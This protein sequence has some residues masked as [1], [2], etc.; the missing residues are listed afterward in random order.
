MV[1]IKMSKCENCRHL[2]CDHSVGDIECM[3]I[4]SMTD[5]EYEEYEETGGLKKCPYFEE[6]VDDYPYIEGLLN[7]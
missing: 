3:K 6:L 1:V 7:R 2:F 4:E 5:E